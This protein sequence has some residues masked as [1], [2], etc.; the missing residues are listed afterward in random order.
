MI[1]VPILLILSCLKIE[2]EVGIG[3]LEVGLG[4]P[5]VML[6]MDLVFV[7]ASITDKLDGYLARS[8]NMVTTFGKFL[9]PLADKILVLSALIVLVQFDKLPAWVPAIILTREFLVSGY[10]LVA[11]EQGGQVIAASFLGKLKTVTQMLAIVLAFV[12]IHGFGEFISNGYSFTQLGFVIN[13]I[14]TVLMSLSIVATI[15]SGYD[16][17]KNGKELFRDG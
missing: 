5:V 2:N 4:I 1:L 12:D 11:V 15:F 16:Y 9:D 14:N 10:R 7:I 8:R 6:F 17:L 3:W 13:V